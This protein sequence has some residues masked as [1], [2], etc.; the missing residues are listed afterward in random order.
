MIYGIGNDLTAISRITARLNDERFLHRVFTP[1]ELLRKDDL[2]PERQAE[3]YAGLF[4]A[5]EAVA[6]AL[7]TGFCGF[8]P[9][10]ISVQSDA[11]GAPS[12]SVSQKVPLPAGARI[13]LSISHDGGFA[14]AF[15]II[16]IIP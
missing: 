11:N 10:D 4:A 9:L 12:A 13:H 8:G 7:R 1:E 16:E 2:C 15:A 5:K 14:A 6:K 3:H